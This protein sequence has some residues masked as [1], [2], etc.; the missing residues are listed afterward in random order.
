LITW[1]S[2]PHTRLRVC[3]CVEQILAFSYPTYVS[4]EMNFLPPSIHCLEH[5]CL[6]REMIQIPQLWHAH[7]FHAWKLKNAENLIMK[8]DNDARCL[9]VKKVAGLDHANSWV[10]FLYR[11]TCINTYLEKMNRYTV[12]ETRLE[13]SFFPHLLFLQWLSNYNFISK[14]PYSFRTLLNTDRMQPH[15]P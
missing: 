12:R 6:V 14:W 3:L 15:A 2:S 11:K 5:K 4:F 7:P 1:R 13:F 9:Y 10:Q 8:E